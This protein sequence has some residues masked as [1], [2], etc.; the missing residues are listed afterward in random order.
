MRLRPLR[1]TSRLTPAAEARRQAAIAAL[2]AAIAEAGRGEPV[3]VLEALA[4]VVINRMLA[5]RARRA[6]ASWGVDLASAL[7]APGLFG[8]RTEAA[9][10]AATAEPGTA[11]A[12]TAEAGTAGAGRRIAA[13]AAAGSLPDPTGG[14]L[15]FHR[16]GTA[17]PD[18]A[19]AGER[20][21]LG[22][23][24]FIRPARAGV[25]AEAADSA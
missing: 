7:G 1:D 16:P 15:W 4:A 6:P 22:G 2:A 25:A 11:G 12:G 24:V 9:P 13:R 8:D 17:P 14:A 21:R 18:G 23:F 20:L 3:R 5:A 19:E 10:E